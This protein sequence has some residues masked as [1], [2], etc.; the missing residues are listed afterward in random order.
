ME[1]RLYQ[2]TWKTLVD[3]KIILKFITNKFG[4]VKRFS[5]LR[6]GKLRGVANMA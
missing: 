3:S 4:S 1:I 5:S 6:T 2:T